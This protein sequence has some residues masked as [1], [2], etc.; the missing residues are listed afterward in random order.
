MTFNI[1]DYA[2]I[3]LVKTIGI[4]ALFILLNEILIKYGTS[5]NNE[6]TAKFP[7]FLSAAKEIDLEN[8]NFYASSSKG[9]NRLVNM[10]RHKV[11]DIPFEDMKL[12]NDVV[13]EL[14][15]E[16]QRVSSN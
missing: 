2:N 1:D 14:N 11:L 12:K 15:Q 16:I 8:S 9:K 7:D 10:L 3:V 5:I 13:I 4:S 6:L